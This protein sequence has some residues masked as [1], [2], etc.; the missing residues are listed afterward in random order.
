MSSLVLGK[1]EEQTQ[2]NA[3]GQAHRGSAERVNSGGNQ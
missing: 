2:E 1:Q 3:M